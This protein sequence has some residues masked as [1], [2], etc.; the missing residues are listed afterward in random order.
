MSH[1]YLPIL[2]IHVIV[3]VLGLGSIASVALVSATARRAGRGSTDAAAWLQ[4]LL[5]YSALSL[6]AMLVTGALLDF[7]AGGAFHEF[8][9]FRGSAIL[10]I[11]TGALHGQARRAMRVGLANEGRGGDVMLRRIERI[12]VIMCALI[13]VIAILMEVKPF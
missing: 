12:A 6:A 2:A 7:T 11:A 3:A 8:W 10:L 9:W 5:R 1:L 4:P 13:A